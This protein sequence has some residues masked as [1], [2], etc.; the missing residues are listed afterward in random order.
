MNVLQSL[1]NKTRSQKTVGAYKMVTAADLRRRLEA[2][3]RGPG[4]Q[5]TKIF[6]IDGGRRRSLNRFSMEGR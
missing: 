5:E 6:F 4:A 1:K 2:L 3:E